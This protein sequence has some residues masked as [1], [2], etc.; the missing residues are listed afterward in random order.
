[1]LSMIQSIEFLDVIIMNK[2]RKDEYG[3]YVIAGGW[4]AR[5]YDN[6]TRFNVGDVVKTYHFGGSSMAGVGKDESCKKGKYL[7]EW[8]TTG[9]TYLDY[10]CG[11]RSPLSDY[12][13]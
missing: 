3:Y 8:K 10:Q 12:C 11:K 7:E 2:I 5:P 4:I 6:Y 9:R 13:A 1:M